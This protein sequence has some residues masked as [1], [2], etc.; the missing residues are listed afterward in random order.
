MEQK[1]CVINQLEN[2]SKFKTAK[3]SRV[4]SQQYLENRL[5]PLQIVTA[6]LEKVLIF[7]KRLL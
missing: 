3:R 4:S 6:V 1:Y 2:R 7:F 5:L